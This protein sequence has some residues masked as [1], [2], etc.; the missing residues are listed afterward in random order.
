MAG[1]TASVRIRKPEDV[2]RALT[3]LEKLSVPVGA[4]VFGGFSGNNLDVTQDGDKITLTLTEVGL[5]ERI[6]S[7]IQASIETIRRRVDAFGTEPAPPSPASNGRAATASLFRC[8]ASP[9]CKG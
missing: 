7:A 8:R 4:D 3:E 6:N 5:T 9:T 2:E 1:R